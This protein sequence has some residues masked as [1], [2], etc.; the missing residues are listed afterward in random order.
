MILYEYRCKRCKALFTLRRKMDCR[1][2]AATCPD[3]GAAGFRVISRASVP[4]TVWA[5]DSDRERI[6][7]AGNVWE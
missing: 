2:E 3:C 4:R 6:L 1:N 7:R 5:A